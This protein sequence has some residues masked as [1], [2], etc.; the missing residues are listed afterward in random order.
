MTLCI[1]WPASFHSSNS[2]ASATHHFTLFFYKFDY[3]R[4]HIYVRAF[5]ACLS[6]FD[7]LTEHNILQVHPCCHRFYVLTEF[8]SFLRLTSISRCIYIIFSL[9]IYLLMD[10]WAL[11]ILY[12]L[13]MHVL[14]QVCVLQISLFVCGFFFPLNSAFYRAKVFEFNELHLINF[15]FH[16][17]CFQWYIWKVITKAKGTKC[18]PDYLSEIL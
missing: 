4:F 16:G 12:V 3:F 15:D 9:S 18:S 6:V 2:S 17:S 13:H 11:N 7:L 10:A 5:A 8:S 1:L 14:S